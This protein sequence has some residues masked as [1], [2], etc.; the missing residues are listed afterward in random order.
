MVRFLHFIFT[1]IF[2]TLIVIILPSPI[3]LSYVVY[4]AEQY[5]MLFCGAEFDEN[6]CCFIDDIN[7]TVRRLS[8][9]LNRRLSHGL[10]EFES[11]HLAHRT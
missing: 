10:S 2:H 8:P 11:K 1:S 5:V 7:I 3:I 9:Y 4:G 6:V